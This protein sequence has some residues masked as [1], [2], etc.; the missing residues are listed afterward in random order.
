[1]ILMKVAPDSLARDLASID[2]PHPGGPYSRTPFGAVRREEESKSWG[3]VRGK[4]T[5][6]RSEVIIFSRPPIS[7]KECKI[8][9]AGSR[10]CIPEKRIVKSAGSMRPAAMVPEGRL[11]KETIIRGDTAYVRIHRGLSD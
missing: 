6:S 2:L 4:I 7:T 1:M 5:D 9:L 8:R 3:W 10:N 11:Q